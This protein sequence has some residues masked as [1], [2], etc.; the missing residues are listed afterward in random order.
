MATSALCCCDCATLFLLKVKNGFNI[1]S[2]KTFWPSLFLLPHSY[3]LNLCLLVYLSFF[4]TFLSII[5][6]ISFY[7]I[8]ILILFSLSISSICPSLQFFFL[9]NLLMSLSFWLASFLSLFLSFF[10]SFDL[11]LFYFNYHSILSSLSAPLFNVHFSS[12]CLSSFLSHS[13]FVVFSSSLSLS[14]HILA[15]LHSNY[16][17]SILLIYNDHLFSF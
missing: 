5:H 7:S 10:Y 9:L 3:F 16:N 11:F 6:Y 1:I 4:P 15:F 8:L 14:S 12:I 17:I 13:I 2:Y